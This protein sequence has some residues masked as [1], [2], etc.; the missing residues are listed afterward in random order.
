VN[1]DSAYYPDW[2]KSPSVNNK[3]KKKENRK[4]PMLVELSFFP[5][6]RQL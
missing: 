3:K 4:G 6:Q 1:T 2:Q 5:W